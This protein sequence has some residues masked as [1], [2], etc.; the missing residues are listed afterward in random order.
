MYML[1]CFMCLLFYMQNIQRKG[2]IRF[3][4]TF[5]VIRRSYTMLL[6]VQ[7]AGKRIYVT[8]IEKVR[9]YVLYVKG[10]YLSPGVRKTTT[11]KVN[12]HHTVTIVLYLVCVLLLLC[13]LHV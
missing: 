5:T 7:F 8:Y 3:P 2:T 13:T 4:Q 11:C 6:H 12:K 10:T 1:T 9:P